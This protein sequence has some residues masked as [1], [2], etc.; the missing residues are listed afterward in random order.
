MQLNVFQYN[1]WLNSSIWPI[2]GILTGT[3]TLGQSGSGS[4]GMNGYSTFPK[5]PGL[6]PHYQMV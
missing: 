6:E 5:A 4:Y 1:K 2:V 3:H